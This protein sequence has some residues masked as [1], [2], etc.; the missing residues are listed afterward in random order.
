M[1]VEKGKWVRIEKIVLEPTCR[2]DNIPEETK[3]TE[4]KMW[5]KG[6]LQHDCYIGESAKIITL[7]N[8]EEVGK[9]VSVNHSYNLDYG[10]FIPEIMKI[11]I[12]CKRELFCEGDHNE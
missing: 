1:R 4:L 11:G 3:K 9:L 5:T 6:I 2:M 10:E 12:D 8:R 7:S